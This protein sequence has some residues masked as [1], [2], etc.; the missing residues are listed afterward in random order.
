VL[1]LV[2]VLVLVQR[3]AK[4]PDLL[5]GSAL[6]AWEQVRDLRVDRS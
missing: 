6:A 4:P 1:V 5:M 3:Q 2:L